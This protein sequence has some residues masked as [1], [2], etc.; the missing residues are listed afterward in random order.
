MQIVIAIGIILSTLAWVTKTNW[1]KWYIQGLRAQLLTVCYILL[2]L[3][4]LLWTLEGNILLKILCTLYL[5]SAICYCL[6][7]IFPFTKLARPE[8]PTNNSNTQEMLLMSANVRMSNQDYGK[9]LDRIEEV[10]PDIVLL[11]E[12]DQSWTDAIQKIES[13]YTH[14]I[15]LPRDNTYGMSLY[16]KFPLAEK[17]IKFL[18][19]EEVASI[20]CTIVHPDLGHVKFMGLHPRPPQPGRREEDKDLELIQAAALAAEHLDPMIVTGDLND[21]AWSPATLHFKT[22]SKLKDP[23]VGR[24]FFSTYN[25]LLPAFRMPI[26]HFFISKHFEVTKIKR[27]EKIGS[28]HFPILLGVTLQRESENGSKF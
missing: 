4:V 10:D 7:N 22:I 2:F 13:R 28:D 18:V 21:V 3:T 14:R 27:L 24:G 8:V 25:A 16:S 15:L 6:H 23:R 11:T 1:R 5:L 12:I 26:D 9:L 20:H 17:L 19:D